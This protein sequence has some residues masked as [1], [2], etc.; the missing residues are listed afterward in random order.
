MNE[1]HLL[2]ADDNPSIHADFQKILG[3]ES[4]AT[5]NLEA[6]QA[7]LFGTDIEPVEEL[8]FSIDSAFQGEEALL[9]VRQGLK[10]NIHYAV[11]FVD[12]R[13]P[14]GI[15][16]VETTK[17]LWELDPNIQVV[18]CTAYTDYSWEEL[19]QRL[20]HTDRLLI[21]KKPFE[22]IEVRQLA[23]A[24]TKKWLVHQQL[25]EYMNHLQDLV[26][27]RTAKLASS[28]AVVKATLN[29]TTDGILVVSKD[30][31][32]IDYNKKF[33]K[34]LHIP[35]PIADTGEDEKARAIVI[36]QIKNPETFI[37]H[38]KEA[39]AH[40]E[41]ELHDIL[42]F[43]D[44]RIIEYFSIPLLV[45]EE[46]T[47]RVFSFRDVTV[48]KKLEK[49]L[50]EHTEK[51]E[52][53]LSLVRATLESTA[54]AILVIDNHHRIVD[55]NQNFVEMHQIPLSILNKHNSPLVLELV[56]RLMEDPKRFIDNVHIIEEHPDQSSF[57]TEVFKDGRIIDCYSH[58][59]LLGDKIIGRVWSL[60]DITAQKKLEEELRYKTT[61]DTLTDVYNHLVLSDRIQHAIS[62]A[63][64]HKRMVA[65]L[66]LDIDSFRLINDTLGHN[67]GD[68]ILKILAK[69]LLSI[70]EKNN[71]LGRVGGD[72]FIIILPSVEKIDSIIATSQKILTK[73]AEPFKI[74]AKDLSITVS[75]GISLYPKDGN[76]ANT[77]IKNASA[78]N[79]SAK[80]MGRN[81]FK[82][83]TAELNMDAVKRLELEN[84]LLRALKQN[85]FILYYQ[86]IIDLATGKIVG[87]EAL[88]RWQHPKLGLMPPQ[89]FVHVAEETGLMSAIGKWV[90]LT[91]C[92]QNKMWQDQGL[93]FIRVAVNLTTK[94]L[95]EEN[96]VADVAEILKQTQLNSKYL[97][98][99]MTETSV[100]EGSDK[101]I[102]TMQELKNIGV[103]LAV[104]DFGTGYSSL[105]YL[106]ELPVDSIKI[107]RTFINY[108][109][110]S[111]NDIMVVSAII[112]MAKSL[113]LR[114]LA[115]GVETK[116]QVDFL[117]QHHCDEL[118]GFYFGHPEPAE[119]IEKILREKKIFK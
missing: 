11:A 76:D 50:K 21:L 28:L 110:K 1:V 62:E 75:I 66:L 42:N 85:E 108:I 83:F 9:L 71:T 80:L 54:D 40:P 94:Q 114:S 41:C 79:D 17:L 56:S 115:E 22:N 29:A 35:Q 111:P 59:Q 23:D 6:T 78:A 72:E 105:S 116:E 5:Q 45:E 24:L 106:Y 34:I 81:N 48:Q 25:Q 26:E 43:K 77:L 92:Q 47:G 37:N 60:R 109:T 69:R 96:F 57:N 107:D 118:Q 31:K 89:T 36:D 97:E 99:E 67:V 7:V 68:D 63:K 112:E 103:K 19:N 30:Q 14:P 55:Y 93:D 13:M 82:F 64:K 87:V 15:D 100:I 2:I 117:R 65:V 53:S 61:H 39:Y 49:Q 70:I 91:A 51:L 18:I 84:D 88:I 46:I 16:G 95:T 52:K 113:K 73:V 102:R 90:L 4:K 32:I 86:P 10:N 58:P 98:L 8:N 38:A 101:I 20:G 12:V 119:T 3:P 74:D 27:E 44:G 104:D 33:L